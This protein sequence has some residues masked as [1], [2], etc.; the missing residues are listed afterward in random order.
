MVSRR[1]KS[2]AT[3]TDARRAAR[4]SGAELI[5]RLR[6]R[7]FGVDHNLPAGPFAGALATD[8]LFVTERQMENSP[9]AAGHRA[10]PE[11]LAGTTDLVGSRGRA[12]A[13]LLDA[14]QA[15]VVGVEPK[16][17]VVF[18]RIAKDLHRQ[19]FER[20]EK[21]SAILEEIVD[22]G[23]RESDDNVGVLDFSVLTV[24]VRDFEL[25]VEPRFFQNGLKKSLNTRS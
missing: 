25:Q 13:K 20:E 9:L 19:V 17:G 5:R 2:T 4:Q 21:L 11:R 24:V 12:Q 10:K 7:T 15:I 1:F 18:G 3:A 6:G 22:V 16:P 23:A 14:E 8:A